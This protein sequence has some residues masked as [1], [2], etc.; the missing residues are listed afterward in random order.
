MRECKQLLILGLL[1]VGF[2][3]ANCD[4]QIATP[5]PVEIV[6][7]DDSGSIPV[8]GDWDVEGASGALEPRL[9]SM[10]AANG[11][12]F[13][14][15]LP[16][17]TWDKESD[18]YYDNTSFK[19]E[20]EFLSFVGLAALLEDSGCYS[21]TVKKLS[22]GSMASSTGLTKFTLCMKSKVQQRGPDRYEKGARILRHT[23]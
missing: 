21:N 11:T 1:E 23:Q 20:Q 7:H 10:T 3:S 22:N 14:C 15:R 9:H 12:R 5:K 2:L 4:F 19:G 8:D 6:I 17:R 18:S 16:V 13:T